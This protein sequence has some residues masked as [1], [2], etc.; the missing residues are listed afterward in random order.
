MQDAN[1]AYEEGI[2][3]PLRHTINLLE[4]RQARQEA[5]SLQLYSDIDILRAAEEHC[6]PALIKSTFLDSIS[7]RT[8]ASNPQTHHGLGMLD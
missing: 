3:S 1:T 8:V 5:L 7:E 6:Y 2:A 4:L